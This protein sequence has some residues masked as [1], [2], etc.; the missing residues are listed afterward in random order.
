MR[1]PETLPA[2]LSR[3]L[4]ALWQKD[5]SHRLPNF[6]PIQGVEWAHASLGGYEGYLESS[7]DVLQLMIPVGDDNYRSLRRRPPPVRLESGVGPG[8][9]AVAPLRT[10][11]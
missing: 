10:L 4:I 7:D 9:G 3:L 6:A 1:K 5:V 11:N 2:D 8:R